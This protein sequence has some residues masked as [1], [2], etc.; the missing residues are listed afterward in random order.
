MAFNDLLV[1]EI[2]YSL[3]GETSLAGVPFTFIRLTGCNLRCTYCDT[4]YAFKGGEKR[5][6]SSLIEAVSRFPTKH[7]LV[8]GGEPLMQRNTLTLVRELSV[9]H[10]YSVSIETHGEA[11]IAPYIGLARIILDI[12]TPSSGMQRGG[13][14]KN[15]PLL[16]ERDEIKFVIASESDYL[17]ARDWVRQQYPHRASQILFSPVLESLDSPK[18]IK[19]L[20]PRWLADQIIKDGLQ[21]RFQIQLHKILW[22]ENTRGV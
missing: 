15:I 8:T 5:S 3:Q 11:D 22:G 1:T 19:A 7:I 10:G 4:A 13:W 14:Q 16:S 6:I 2:F 21:V 17:W 12:K 9:I 18:K 20:S